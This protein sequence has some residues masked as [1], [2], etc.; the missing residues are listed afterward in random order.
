[1]RR[2]QLGLS[3]VKLAEQADV[4]VK[5]ITT[6][7][8]RGVPA[9]ADILTIAR[10]EEG[11]GVAPGW[12][13][14]DATRF[15]KG[16][17]RSDSARASEQSLT[18][19]SARDAASAHEFG[20]RERQSAADIVSAP[21]EPKAPG[22]AER[23][24]AVAAGV[25]ARLRRKALRIPQSRLANV[26][27]VA[28]P[29]LARWETGELPGHLSP[30][31]IRLWEKQLQVPAGWL[32]DV[33]AALVEAAAPP[34]ASPRTATMPIPGSGETTGTAHVHATA[35]GDR[36]RAR[37]ESL[38]IRRARL[39]RNIGVPSTN[40][41]RWERG[42]IPDYLEASTIRRWEAE[43]Q[44]APGW[45]IDGG[46]PIGEKEPGNTGAAD[47][48][49]SAGTRARQ[50]R[51]SLLISRMS[52]ALQIGV[53]LHT[54]GRWE[55]RGLPTRLPL[56]TRERWER[57]LSVEDG[58]L[59]GETS[60]ERSRALVDLHLETTIRGVIEAV[61]Q[62][63]A[64]PPVPD[65]V[66]KDG[67]GIK[68]AA[69]A[70][71]ASVFAQR[72]GV[73]ADADT[74]FEAIAQRNSITL[75]RVSQIMTALTELSETCEIVA[76]VFERLMEAARP[77]LPCTETHLQEVLL[78]LL[79]GRLPL[80]GVIRF[81]CEILRRPIFEILRE[82]R[83]TGGEVI[84]CDPEAGDARGII[85]QR[86]RATIKLA[87]AMIRASG[88]A[89]LGLLMSFATAQGWEA[90]D[91]QAMRAHLSA[92]TGFEWL[93]E[94]DNAEPQW[95]W[96]ND[97]SAGPG[98]VDQAL[99][100]VF[101]VANGPVG[102]ESMLGAIDRVRA[103]RARAQ[104]L[105]P[106]LG[107]NP[108]AHVMRAMLQRMDWLEPVHR[109]EFRT[110]VA[111]DPRKELPPIEFLL[112][113]EMKRVGG[114]ATR[115]EVIRK[116]ALEGENSLRTVASLFSN[117]PVVTRFCKGVYLLRG[118]TP[119]AHSFLRAMEAARGA[120]SLPDDA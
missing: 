5:S 99:R 25:R 90:L 114:A 75:S 45:L 94:P 70:R 19:T 22:G 89:H 119:S 11:L 12:L 28:G 88:A 74:N 47:D 120:D 38:G 53:S 60:P 43:L 71:K 118:F 57:A 46:G 27:G 33:G 18:A 87:H 51:E 97:G 82:E 110:A 58:W 68:P 7:E 108:P 13:L 59:T 24:G 29:S 54:L 42:G 96:F 49:V 112:Y 56:A 76:P 86:E 6:W 100:R 32:K 14:G 104:E 67:R 79:G 98:P 93:E 26:L 3:R 1:M 4:P 77:H 105:S 37:R 34:E 95:F 78:P 50:R 83:S 21:V 69:V 66:K 40:I 116:L 103:V 36:A 115:G 72:Y 10:W 52:M 55:A 8:T 44:V 113:E 117:S 61:T 109:E 16:A 63:L 48:H 73:G 39:A 85:N 30:A 23:D 81:A 17:R 64:N 35:T 106:I 107:A 91:V 31:I 102:F 80:D 65:H 20:L 2:E 9:D 15:G 92:Q 62:W 84:V 41:S 101:S 111:L